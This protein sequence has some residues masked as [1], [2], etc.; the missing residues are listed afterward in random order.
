MNI[1]NLT[2]RRG[3]RSGEPPATLPHVT[4]LT[5]RAR[6]SVETLVGPL[7]SRQPYGSRIRHESTEM[8]DIQCCR[9]VH[10]Y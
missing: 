8:S 7:K 2:Q 10:G 4:F 9:V 5:H 1:G 3:L 6:T